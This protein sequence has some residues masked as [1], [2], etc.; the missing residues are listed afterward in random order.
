[1]RD[2]L[3][4]PNDSNVKTKMKS[5]Q[6]TEIS[7]KT[8]KRVK[9]ILESHSLSAVQQTN[10]AAGEIYKWVTKHFFFTKLAN[11]LS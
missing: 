10:M 8:V 3:R 5:I 9:S 4:C 11:K 7:V 2:T 1:M 6:K